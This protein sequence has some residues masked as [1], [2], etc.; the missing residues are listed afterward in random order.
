LLVLEDEVVDKAVEDGIR[1]RPT[2]APLIPFVWDIP[3]TKSSQETP[4]CSD[5]NDKKEHEKFL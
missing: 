1:G 4:D 3:V 2:P 5:P